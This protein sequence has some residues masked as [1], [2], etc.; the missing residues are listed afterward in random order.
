M[1]DISSEVRVLNMNQIS[2]WDKIESF[3]PETE[4]ETA[5]M[6]FVPK[7][8][9]KDPEVRKARKKQMDDWKRFEAYEEVKD[10]GQD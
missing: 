2:E 3:T 9:L 6:V 5:F 4:E 1:N 7:E 8:K 10:E